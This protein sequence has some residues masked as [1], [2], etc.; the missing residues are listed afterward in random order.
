MNTKR[1]IN[2]FVLSGAI[3]LP[4]FAEPET[5]AATAPK[6]IVIRAQRNANGVAKNAEAYFVTS[7]RVLRVTN[8]ATAHAMNQLLRGAPR[9][10]LNPQVLQN[11]ATIPPR[12]DQ[13]IRYQQQR[14]REE[15]AG[16]GESVTEA[17]DR[18]ASA[19]GLDGRL[20]A[21]QAT[22]ATES[23]D[24]RRGFFFLGL[25]GYPGFGWGGLGLGGLWGWG[26][27]G[28]F[29]AG[30]GCGGYGYGLGY[31][32]GYGYPCFGGLG[33]YNGSFAYPYVAA[34]YAL[35]AAT[36]TYYYYYPSSYY[37]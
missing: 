1:W 23:A 18:A 16:G 30:L 14:F 34:P 13:A 8:A 27:P 31:L 11:N 2:L 5:A 9:V 20:L 33:W 35:A 12:V 25:G 36:T 29:G 4:A 3:S 7:G 15:S 17:N 26:Y 37:F 24:H 28:Y 21:T 22:D 6:M 32:G 10:Q 19:E